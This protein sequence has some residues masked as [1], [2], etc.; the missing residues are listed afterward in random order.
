MRERIDRKYLLGMFLMF[1][2]FHVV[3]ETSNNVPGMAA[4]D[5]RC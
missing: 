1:K 3:P 4:E 2:I 5:S